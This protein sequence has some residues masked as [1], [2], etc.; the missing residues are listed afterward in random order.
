MPRLSGRQR[1]GVLT[2]MAF[3]NGYAVCPEDV[4][5]I[6]AGEECDV[7]LIDREAPPPPVPLLPNEPS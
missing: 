7:I 3:A 5:V 4:A 1:S 6:E 2:S